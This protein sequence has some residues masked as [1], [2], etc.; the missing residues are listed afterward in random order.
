M[1]TNMWTRSAP[2]ARLG[3]SANR[4]SSYRLAGAASGS[5]TRLSWVLASVLW[6][7]GLRRGWACERR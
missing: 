4:D 3:H 2:P 7:A 5:G 6:R 1:S